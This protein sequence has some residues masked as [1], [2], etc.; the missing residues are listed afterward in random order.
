MNR[1]YSGAAI[2]TLVLMVLPACQSIP[3]HALD[4]ESSLAKL[5][6]R[7]IH[8]APVVDYARTQ[9]EATGISEVPFD[10]SD[11]LSLSEAEAVARWYNTD[12]RVTRLEADRLGA[13][14][15]VAGRWED[16]ALE[17][18]GGRQR[19]TLEDLEN[20]REFI[21]RS[22]V[23]AA[24]LQV[25]IPLSGRV[26]AGRQARS[27]EHHAALLATAEAEWSAVQ[28]LRQHWLQWSAALERTRLLDAQLVTLEQFS[29]IAHALSSAGEL[30]PGGARMFAIALAQLRAQRTEADSE[31][32]ELHNAII[33]QLGLLPDAPVTLVPS[34][35]STIPAPPD[36]FNREETALRHP[37]ME[38]RVAEYDAAEARLRHELRKQ[39][40]DITLSP[41]YNSERDKSAVVLGLGF[42][43][44]VWNANRP[45]IADAVAARDV[46]RARAEAQLQQLISQFARGEIRLE[47]ARKRRMELA[48]HGAPEVDRQLTEALA[49][50]HAGEAD[51]L[52]LLQALTQANEIKQALLDA[53]LDEQ[54]ALVTLSSPSP[55]S[56]APTTDPEVG[57]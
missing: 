33:E 40:P 31:G 3:P 21:E 44:P 50:L 6:S 29:A 32:A 42:P 17:L 26:S 7:E 41:G 52:M 38:Q 10:A 20:A 53:T 11:G 2:A 47:S 54:I 35:Q 46:A 55:P 12:L 43:I 56:P 30:E 39:Y 36:A 24:S 15:E 13:V 23:S 22:W 14:A 49:L 1:M 4:L 19:E 51:A 45:D 5:K 28:T 25:T 48:N 34:L 16:P 9:V 18:T 57:P 8:V 27:A 37:A